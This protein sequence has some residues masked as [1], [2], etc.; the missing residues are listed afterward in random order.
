MDDLFF[1]GP[2]RSTCN[3]K[4]LTRV[5]QRF[6]HFLKDN[7]L[8]DS[9]RLKNI[10]QI[11]NLPQTGV[12]IKDVSNPHVDKLKE[13]FLWFFK[14]VWRAFLFTRSEGPVVVFKVDPVPTGPFCSPQHL[15]NSIKEHGFSVSLGWWP[16]PTMNQSLVNL[17]FLTLPLYTHPSHPIHFYENLGS[18]WVPSPGLTSHKSAFRPQRSMNHMM[19][20]F[21]DDV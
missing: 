21:W 2:L 7:C 14:H 19:N 18:R 3:R 6:S 17:D 8:V 12:K 4:L 1:G 20:Q 5:F 10:S 16:D 11:G 15:L 13:T 9:T